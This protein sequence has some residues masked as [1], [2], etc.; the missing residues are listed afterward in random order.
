MRRLWFALML[1]ACV[2]G[3]TISTVSATPASVSLRYFSAWSG[4]YAK[5][6][7]RAEALC[8]Q[9]GKHARQATTPVK[10][11]EDWSVATF[12]CVP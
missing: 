4:E 5:V 6:V 7:Q 11:S 2:Q 8:Q 9:H 12:D 1:V 10:T 3:R